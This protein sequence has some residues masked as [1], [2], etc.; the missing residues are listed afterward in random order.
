MI[1]S[2]VTAG[3]SAD[4]PAGAGGEAL[5]G[6]DGDE[7][8]NELR[9][10]GEDV[11]DES[12]A[13]VGGVQVLVQRSEADAALAQL[14]DH[15]DEV[16]EAATVAVDGRGDK[17]VARVEERVTRLQLGT[18]R[19]LPGLLVREDL[20]APGDGEVSSCRSSFCPPVD[21]RTRF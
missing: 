18:E 13:G 15:V 17:R 20:P 11:E 3:A 4:P 21:T 6:A 16:L 9:E 2:V 14:G 10:R 12:A 19:V 7:C 5:L 8:A 1:S